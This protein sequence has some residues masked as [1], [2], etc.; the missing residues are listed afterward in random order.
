MR[1]CHSTNIQRGAATVTRFAKMGRENAVCTAGGAV[2]RAFVL[3][4]RVF[5]QATQRG[6]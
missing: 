5:L 1:T 6:L 2:V 4:K 3:Q